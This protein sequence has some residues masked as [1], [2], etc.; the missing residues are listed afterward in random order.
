[1]GGN[2][3]GYTRVMT[4]TIALETDKGNFELA[5]ALGMILPGDLVRGQRAASR[6]S[7]KR[8][9]AESMKLTASH[10]KKNYGGRAILQDCTVSFGEHGISVL[11]GS[12]G[13]GKSTFF[14]ICALLEKPDEG[15]LLFAD[16]GAALEQDLSLMRRITLVLP[17]TGVF[18]A[19]ALQNVAY[20]LRIRGVQK[21]E[22]EQRVAEALAFVGLEH[23]K[24]QA[25]RTLSSGEAQRL[26][27]ARALVIRPEILF[28]D[29]PTASVD[30]E[31]TG[32]IESIILAMKK[33]ARTTVVMTTHDRDQAM[34]LA[35]RLLLYELGRIVEE[36]RLPASG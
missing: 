22:L 28:L 9:N 35:D 34:R 32:I 23:K 27:I 3:A 11:M 21:R 24:N 33:E 4:T 2:I 29:E 12:N 6:H 26:G 5:L 7:E 18:N 8:F 30:E 17:R 20:G 13:C 31:N 14:R 25:A 16:N 1:M 10:I 36:P 15:E 19:T